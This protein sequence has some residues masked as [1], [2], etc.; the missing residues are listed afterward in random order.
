MQSNSITKFAMPL[1]SMPV[2]TTRASRG[3]QHGVREPKENRHRPAVDT[4]FRSAA[5]ARGL[6]V[7]GVVLTGALNAG[8][9]GSRLSS[10]AARGVAV[11]QD[12][13]DALRVCRSA[14]EH[15]D[16][17]LCLPLSKIA[18]QSACIVRKE[19]PADEQGVYGVPDEIEK[20][21]TRLDPPTPDNVPKLGHPSVF[22]CPKRDEHCGKNIFSEKTET[23]ETA[24]WIVLNTL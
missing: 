24:L 18:P 7:V 2:R 5:L 15:V 8:S 22:A 1:P 12:P 13:D 20:E 6:R 10:S 17:D 19:I 9:V 21:M 4:L 14:L 23:L 3:F 11:V 16:V